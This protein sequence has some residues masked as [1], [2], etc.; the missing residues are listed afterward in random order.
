MWN[1]VAMIL[2]SCVSANHLGLIHAIENVI[3]RNIPVINCS[4]CCSFWFVLTYMI[5]VTQDIILSFATSFIC[6]II[7]PWTELLM[8]LLDVI[9]NKTYDKIYSTT[10]VKDCSKAKSKNSQRITLS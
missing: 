2:F 6:A 3:R 9:F 5:Y 7:A 4:R 1:D 8:G 10:K